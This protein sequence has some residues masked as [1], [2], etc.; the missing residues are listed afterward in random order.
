MNENET[1][2]IIS[3]DEIAKRLEMEALIRGKGSI[4]FTSSEINRP[5]LQ[6][7][8][9]YAH[10]AEERVQ[11]IGNAEMNYL[12]SLKDDDLFAKMD[13]FMSSGIPCVVCARSNKPPDILLDR[14]ERHNVPIFLSSR[15]TDDIGQLIGSFVGRYLAPKIKLH[16]VLLDIFG[17]G[18]LLIGES[19]VGKSETALEMIKQG[20]RLVSDDVVEITRVAPD[21]LIGYAPEITRHLIEVRGVGIV[22][23]RYMFG[24]SAEIPEKGIDIVIEM[25]LWDQASQYERLGTSE[26]ITQILGVNVP[27]IVIPVRPGRNLAVVLEVAARSFRLKRMGYDAAQ[28]FKDRN[29]EIIERMNSYE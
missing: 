5:G 28:D 24:A 16:G 3:V 26:T 14:A 23:V 2:A 19:G 27:K 17:V 18:I 22:D 13:Y 9:Y 15:R 4:E 1:S 11:L 10:F 8:G 29:I 12:Y 7:T 21:K 20:H 6:F 25:E